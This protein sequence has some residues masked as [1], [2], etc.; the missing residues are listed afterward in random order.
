MMV[1]HTDGTKDRPHRT[2]GSTLLP[3]YFP[4]ICGSNPEPQ[5]RALF[6]LHCLN[7]YSLGNI[8]QRSCNLCN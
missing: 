1:L 6:S 4:H 5:Y 3:D 8:H 7:N 2:S